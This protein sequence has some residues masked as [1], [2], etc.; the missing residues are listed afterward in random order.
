[1]SKKMATGGKT[2][3]GGIKTGF[4]AAKTISGKR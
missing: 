4:A 2:K 3:L 1:M